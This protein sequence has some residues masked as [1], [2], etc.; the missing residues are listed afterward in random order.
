ME[1]LVDADEQPGEDNDQ[2][3]DE[4][5]DVEA[6]FAEI[7]GLGCAEGDWWQPVD[8]G[9][10]SGA[11]RQDN[12]AEDH[13]GDLGAHAAGAE[14]VD[15]AVIGGA[16]CFHSWEKACYCRDWHD[17]GWQEGDD[18]VGGLAI[19]L[20]VAIDAMEVR[21]ESVEA[22]DD[23]GDEDDDGRDDPHENGGKEQAGWLAP[24]D[25]RV[26]GAQYALGE[27]HVDGE[28]HDDA[29][30][31]EDVGGDGEADVV[32]MGCPGHA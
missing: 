31:D 29:G 14:F 7:P 8:G 19:E 15:V 4:V 17:Q 30:V 3:D 18:G 9:A 11:E 6:G 1:S 27:D 23:G 28:E 26:L 10:E 20:H 12:G 22:L 16:R 13:D 2:F 5:E 25:G 24:T 21:R 32:D